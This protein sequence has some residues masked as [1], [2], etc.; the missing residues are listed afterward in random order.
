MHHDSSH[1]RHD[2]KWQLPHARVACFELVQESRHCQSF[3]PQK[4]SLPKVAEV[5]L[6]KEV[7]QDLQ[8]CS[9]KEGLQL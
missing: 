6:H 2:V 3:V 4:S 9:Q 1:L 5:P 7:R 8:R